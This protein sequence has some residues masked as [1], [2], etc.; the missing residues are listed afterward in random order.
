[1]VSEAPVLETKYYTPPEKARV[2]VSLERQLQRRM[3]ILY[4]PAG[5]AGRFQV[6]DTHLH[7]PMKVYAQVFTAKWYTGH[8][9][10]LNSPGFRGMQL[11]ILVVLLLLSSALLLFL[12]LLLLLLLHHES[13]VGVLPRSLS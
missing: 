5:G 10:R 1:M 13:P 4:V 6:N 2:Q 8:V 7:K 9:M 3:E 12:H 11:L